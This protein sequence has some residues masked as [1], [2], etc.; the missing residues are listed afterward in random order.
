MRLGRLYGYHY[1]NLKNRTKKQSQNQNTLSGKE[2]KKM[3][4]STSLCRAWEEAERRV[5][6]TR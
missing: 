6:D 2:K 1:K 4:G 5:T 3:H